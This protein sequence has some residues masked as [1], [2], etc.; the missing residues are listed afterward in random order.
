ML[1]AVCALF[2]STAA[3]AVEYY[4]SPDNGN[5]TN[6]GTFDKPW[7]TARRAFNQAPSN[8]APLKPG[9]IVHFRN[10]N[11]VIKDFNHYLAPSISG[12]LGGTAGAPIT[13]KSYGSEKATIVWDTSS[14]PTSGRS[15]LTINR[16]YIVIDGLNFRQTEASRSLVVVNQTYRTPRDLYPTTRGII[17]TATNATIKNCSIDN[18]SG[19]GIS[20]SNDNGGALNTRVENCKIT[21]TA[22]HGFYIGGRDGTYLNNFLDGSRGYFNQQ[23]IQVQ[24]KEAVGNKIYG[25][26][27]ANGQ[28]SGIVLSGSVSNNEVF[29]NVFINGGYTSS[30]GGTGSGHALAFACYDGP[31]GSGNKVYNNT[32]IGKT[33]GKLVDDLVTPKCSGIVPGTQVDIR[34]NIF[35][36]STARPAGLST[37]NV[38][39]NLFY[40]I[41]SSSAPAGNL[42]LD[43]KLDNPLGTSAAAAAL[44]SGSPAI[45]AGKNTTGIPL[46]DFAGTA[47]PQGGVYDIGAYEFKATTP[48][49]PPP[50]TLQL[51]GHWRL[52]ETSGATTADASGNGNFG[53]HVNTPTSVTGKYGRSRSFSGNVGVQSTNDRILIGDPSNGSLD[54]GTTSFSYGLWVNVSVT[55]GI[56]DMAWSKSNG[57][58]NSAGYSMQLGSGRWTACIADGDEMPCANFSASPITGRWVHLMAAVDRSAARLNTYVDGTLVTAQV[59]PTTLGSLSGIKPAAIGADSTGGHPFLGAID[60]VRIYSRALTAA[61]VKQVMTTP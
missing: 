39:N 46:T 43:P 54:F 37:S 59:L 30:T 32:F 10:G 6:P 15:I 52:D 12:T 2:A 18:T 14:L 23:G 61:E 28:A 40:N 58:A 35:H 50:A 9:D 7:Q 27:I 29:N 53:T 31:M 34:D 4:V 5:D 38:R 17:V 41:T 60:D 57:N 13:F 20:V 26:V 8:Q 51:V 33:A 11:Y 22:T 1:F 42:L 24:Y 56:Y 48:P 36:P 44:R 49:P 47:R 25:N 55:A 21:N 16:P 45:N 3:H 19:A